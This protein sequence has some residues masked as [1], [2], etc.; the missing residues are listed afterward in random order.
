MF[1]KHLKIF[2]HT[3]YKIILRSRSAGDILKSQS[4]FNEHI[5]PFSPNGSF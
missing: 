4:L 3:D 5:T 1:N 2:Q